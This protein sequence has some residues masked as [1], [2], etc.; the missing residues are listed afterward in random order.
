VE[1][2]PGIVAAL[3]VVLVIIKTW[4]LPEDTSTDQNSPEDE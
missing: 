2:I 3:L 1:R 4:N